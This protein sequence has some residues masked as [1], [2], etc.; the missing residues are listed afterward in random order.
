M[1]IARKPQKKGDCVK[2]NPKK[3]KGVT[4]TKIDFEMQNRQ[5]ESG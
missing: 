1:E 3:K 2:E 5:A 4:S